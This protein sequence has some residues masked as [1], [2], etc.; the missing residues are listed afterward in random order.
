PGRQIQWTHL[1]P[2]NAHS[3]CDRAAGDYYALA[4]TTDELRH[5]GCETAKLFVIECV[6]ARPSENAGAELDEN[7]SGSL[8]HA[9]PTQ[10]GKRKC[11]KPIFVTLA[12]RNYN[13]GTK[14]RE[15]S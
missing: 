1:Q 6:G 15:A 13:C 10:T 14:I 5:I 8:V 9:Q 11:A 2:D 12:D 4:S 3:G 7:A